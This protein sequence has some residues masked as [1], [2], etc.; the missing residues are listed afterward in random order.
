MHVLLSIGMDDLKNYGLRDVGYWAISDHKSTKHLSHMQ[1]IQ[2]NLIE[3]VGNKNNIVYAFVA[4]EQVLYFGET[5]AGLNSRFQG[6]RYGNPLESDTD[7]RIKKAITAELVSGGKVS[8]W[9]SQPV[10]TLRL[11]SGELLEIPAS[12]PLEEYLISKFRPKLNVKNL[13]K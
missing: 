9:C 13:Q 1:G 3:E 8:I 12:K 2:F 10:G 11:P 7:N 5:T 4:N 6:Y